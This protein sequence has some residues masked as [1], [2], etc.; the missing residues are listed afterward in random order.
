MN[1]LSGP[2]RFIQR[3]ALKHS[4]DVVPKDIV[5]APSHNGALGYTPLMSHSDRQRHLDGKRLPAHVPMQHRPVPIWEVA[6]DYS[7]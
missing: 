4:A 3:D 7:Q 5:G 6:P 2:A 1:K